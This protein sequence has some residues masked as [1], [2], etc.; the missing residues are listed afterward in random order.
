M[1]L[2]K[3]SFAAAALFMAGAMATANAASFPTGP[4]TLVVPTGP[5]GGTD[6][7]ARAFS[8][9]L[10]Q[11]LGQPVVIDNKTGAG[12]IIGTQAVAR[13]KPDGHTLLIS[14]NQFGM[15]P[16]VQSKLPYDPK[17]DFIP[18]TSVGVI[19]SL[20]I[21]NSSAPYSSLTD[22]I[23]HAKKEPGS[24]QYATAGI[25]S[26]NHLFAA[27]FANMADVNLLHVP[28]RGT[29]PALLAVASQDVAL[30]F[31]SYPASQ[32]MIASGKVKPLAVTSPKRLKALPDVPTVSETVP[33]YAIDIWLGIWGVA[34][35]PQ[36]VIDKLHA[37]IVE[38]L[39]DP[40]VT[41]NLADQGI[42]VETRSQS[43]FAAMADAELDL[44]KKVVDDSKGEIQRQ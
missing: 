12:G 30:T 38:T 36:D 10:A 21:V 7:A 4:I 44:W 3:F 43:D 13:A 28:F 33:D 35:T 39:E 11:K 42:I 1:S 23:Q 24:V 25:G 6:L 15:I 8:E 27:M 37:A 5:G 9:K 16:A 34:G 29:A 32:G 19:P 14:S 40:E 22:L 31:A 18:I 20:V 26:P 2:S 17:G 41:K